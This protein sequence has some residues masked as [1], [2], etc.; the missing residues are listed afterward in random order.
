[1]IVWL[2]A[3]GKLAAGIIFY[4]DYFSLERCLASLVNGI[5]IIFAIDGKFPNF[6]GDSNL[7]TDGS[8]DLVESYP[9]CMLID[10]PRSEFEKCSKY[11]EYCFTYSVDILLIIDSDEFVLNNA[12]WN[13]FRRNHKRTIF[14]RDKSKH[15]IYALK[16]QT[17]GKSHELLAYPRTW[18]KPAEMEYYGGQHYYFRNKDPLINNVPHQG[19][20]S[21]NVIELS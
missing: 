18:Y 21:L 14:D 6:L 3:K 7:S 11:L 8:R 17:V 13:I 2:L 19:N 15:N 9:R 4:N 5:G 1:M 16:V 10:F 20:H 12:D